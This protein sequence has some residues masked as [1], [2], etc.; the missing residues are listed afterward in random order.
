MTENKR[1]VFM[2]KIKDFKELINL[3]KDL[4]KHEGRSSFYEVT[5]EIKFNNDAFESVSSDFLNDQPWIEKTDGGMN[6]KGQIRCIR[7]INIDTK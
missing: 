5:K 6:D 7:V 2:R 1:V 4:P 3:T